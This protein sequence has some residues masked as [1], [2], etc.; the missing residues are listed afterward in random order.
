[1][2]VS[3]AAP[4]VDP[5]PSSPGEEKKTDPSGK[6]TISILLEGN[7]L[8]ET[9]G[10]NDK[11]YSNLIY[12]LPPESMK[13]ASIGSLSPVL[14]SGPVQSKVLQDLEPDIL[15]VKAIE[16]SLRTAAESLE[17]AP[18]SFA[19]FTTALG[20]LQNYAGGAQPVDFENVTDPALIALVRKHVS[21]SD[22]VYRILTIL[23]PAPT[24]S[25]S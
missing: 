13:L 11:L 20:N 6:E 14:P 15:N 12:R 10:L 19:P 3:E 8:Q 4:L 23:T 25:T 1:M 18:N 24:R 7:T 2:L 22:G 16:D 21:H 5:V 17:L 9:L